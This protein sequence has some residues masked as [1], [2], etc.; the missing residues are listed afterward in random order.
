[1]ALV[2]THWKTVPTSQDLLCV[3]VSTLKMLNKKLM[4]RSEP[5]TEIGELVRR[6]LWTSKCKPFEICRCIAGHTLR[7]DEH[8][9]PRT[10]LESPKSKWKPQMPS[11]SSDRVDLEM[12]QDTG[13]VVFANL[14]LFNRKISGKTELH[15]GCSAVQQPLHSTTGLLKGGSSVA[16]SDNIQPTEATYGSNSNNATTTMDTSVTTSDSTQPTVTNEISNT[17]EA[18]TTVNT[19]CATDTIA[20]ATA[21]TD[22]VQSQGKE[23]GKSKGK[24]RRVKEFL[25]RR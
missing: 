23:K 14:G 24:M 11:K 4:E 3:S 25:R 9:D 16:M 13:A 15:E 1:V 2:C 8:L 19:A 18:T 12:L 22:T 10:F 17:T 20:S 5:T 7:H 21:V 6:L